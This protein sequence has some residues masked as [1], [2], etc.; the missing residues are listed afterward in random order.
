VEE[1]GTN[2]V[3]I[4]AHT[5]PR[6]VAAGE[7]L[8]FNFGLLITPV[9]TLDKNHWQWRYFQSTAASPVA[10][11]ARKGATVINLH[12]G[13]A[14]GLNPYINYP[15]LTTPKLASYAAEAHARNLK[16]KIYYTVR[17]L[18][19]YAAELW[20]LRSL[21]DEIYQTGPGF[22]LGDQFADK[23]ANSRKPTGSAWLREHLVSGYVPA[24]HQPLGN[25]HMDAA[26]ATTGLSR[27]HNYY[28]EGLNWLLRNV[29]IDGLYLDGI[30]Y[31]R[32]IMKRVRKV[33]QRAHPD[34]LIDFHSGNNFDPRYG[35]NNCANQYL[36]M[37]PFIDSLWFG[38]GFDYNEP[39]DYWMVEMAGIP[40][41][42]FG[43]MLQG[44][45]NPWRGMVYGMTSRLGWGG[46]PRALWKV[47]DE[48]GIAQ[49]RMIGYWDATCPVKTGRDDVLATVYQREGQTLV[50]LASWASA[51][52]SVPLALDF[53]RL[54]LDPA[55]ARL[56]APRISGFQSE[57]LFDPGKPIPVTPGRG[58]LLLVDERPLPGAPSRRS[59]HGGER[60]RGH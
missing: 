52:A 17:E 3:V 54:G 58:W 60:E 48:F 51:T 21:G 50:A 55:K 30:G 39:P 1:A 47:W 18:S 13:G 45:G 10:E 4:R 6:E 46:D 15:F 36:E 31:D 23:S 22:Q 5:G 42:L 25:A 26:I 37:F 7:E 9:K 41:G 56:Y 16:F 2:Q 53:R 11:V 49:S 34:G 29:G 32:E 19:N 14:D 8:H 59:V 27:W 35:L 28:L 38:E 20:A 43:E 33:L 57:A 24:W 40:H 44:G 12:Q